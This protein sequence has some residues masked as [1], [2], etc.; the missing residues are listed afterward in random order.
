MCK[1]IYKNQKKQSLGTL[2]KREKYTA[3][4]K[5]DKNPTPSK[6]E[7]ITKKIDEIINNIYASIL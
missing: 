4:K 1:N 6:E 3:K 5:Q 7:I 2:T